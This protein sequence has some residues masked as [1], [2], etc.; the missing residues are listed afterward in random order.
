MG[1][2][3]RA[4]IAHF[5]WLLLLHLARLPRSFARNLAFSLAMSTAAKSEYCARVVPFL[6]DGARK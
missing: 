4:E 5:G 3:L 2:F 1:G 6:N